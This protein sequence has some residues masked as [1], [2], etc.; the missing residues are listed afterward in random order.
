MS[1]ATRHLT[2]QHYSDMPYS[3]RVLFTATLL[4]LGL[5]YLFALTLIFVTYAGRAGGTPYILSYQ[6]I[7]VAYSG[8]GKAST[9]ESALGGFPGE[10]VHQRF[11]FRDDPFRF[12]ALAP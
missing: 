7:V 2:V 3:Q 9:L 11:A 10:A 5:G 1:G 4:L 12:R 8:S 6:D